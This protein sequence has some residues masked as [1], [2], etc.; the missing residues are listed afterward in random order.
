MGIKSWFQHK[1]DNWVRFAP[2]SKEVYGAI[3]KLRIEMGQMR[4]ALEL[5]HDLTMPPPGFLQ[6]RV[7]G[8]IFDGYVKSGFLNIEEFDKALAVAGTSMRQ[9]K[10]ILD[11]GC[12]CGRVALAV[13]KQFPEANVSGADIDPE[14]IAY[15]QKHFG[16]WASF[17][18]NPDVPPSTLPPSHFDFIYGISVFT[19][20]PEDLQFKWLEEL[21]RIAASGALLLLT[22][23]NA[24]SHFVL[25]DSEKE[26]LGEK[27]FVY[28]VSKATEG[29]P[30][31]YQT[32][33]HTHD[34][35]RKHWAGYFEIL[36]FVPLGMGNH[37]DFV[38]CRKR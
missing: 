18:C 9:F 24:K 2:A 21:N 32:A 5:Y 7:V 34:Y 6:Q 28:K 8:G 12:G 22:I 38:V 33:M 31:Y 23:E 37:Q 4:E 30:D 16:K 29:L 36:D 20:L 1:I 17:Y 10:N 14:A 15:C 11:F 25:S 13:K 19:H 27:G 3:D 26:I 35:V